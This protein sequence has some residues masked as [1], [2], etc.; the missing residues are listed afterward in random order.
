MTRPGCHFI[1][2]ALFSIHVKLRC[3]LSWNDHI[4]DPRVAIGK[5]IRRITRYSWN[6]WLI[7]APSETQDFSGRWWVR[8]C[9]RHGA[10]QSSTRHSTGRAGAGMRSWHLRPTKRSLGKRERE[11]GGTWPGDMGTRWI[12]HLFLKM[13]GASHVAKIRDG[14]ASF[15][16]KLKENHQ[17]KVQTSPSTNWQFVVWNQAFENHQKIRWDGFNHKDQMLP[18]T[19]EMW[20][21]TQVRIKKTILGFTKLG[22]VGHVLHPL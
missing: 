16:Q 17:P 1:T 19:G 8:P 14:T 7:F 15:Y 13:C 20:F 6:M 9:A 4:F 22:I 12:R 3:V 18:F 11:R 10:A 5:E 21:W 2:T